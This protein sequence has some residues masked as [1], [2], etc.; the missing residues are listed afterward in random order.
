MTR[1]IAIAGSLLLLTLCEFGC[2][3]SST[4]SIGTSGSTVTQAQ[5]TTAI[6]DIF[7]AL[8]SA[9]LGSATATPML[10]KAESAGLGEAV[11]AGTA[12]AQSPAFVPLVD[13]PM[14][15]TTIP[16]FTYNCPGGGTIVVNGSYSGTANSASLSII[17]TINSCVD[18][19]FTMSG[20]PNIA[21]NDTLTD[22]GK[23]TTDVLT[24]TGGIK[25]TSS[26]CTID[27]NLT[28]TITDSTGAGSEVISGSFCGVTLSGSYSL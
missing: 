10:R 18:G 2:G 8:A 23:V 28:A 1:K 7:T 21:I 4:T 12:T 26:S 22:T 24:M 14:A 25:T 17:E 5:A 13:N 20:N 19:G 16:A 15:A 9:P 27:V 11:Q 6:N 3:G